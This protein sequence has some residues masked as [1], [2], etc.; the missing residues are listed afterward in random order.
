MRFGAG[1]GSIMLLAVAGTASAQP[2]PDP[3][4]LDATQLRGRDIFN[5]SC[6]VCHVKL[7]ITSPAKYGPDLSKE[8]L[9]GQEAVMRDVISNG[10]AEHAG[11][12]VHVR[13]G[14]D[15]RHHRLREDIADAGQTEPHVQS[16]GQFDP[17]NDIS[18]EDAM[19]HTRVAFRTAGA[20]AVLTALAGLPAVAADPAMLSGTVNSSAGESSAA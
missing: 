17:L 3:S 6:L 14:P 18:G 7:Q 20:A 2:F 12:Q 1:I 4:T 16:D 8:A 15:R 10:D 11:L 19:K 9:G 5:Q 13:A